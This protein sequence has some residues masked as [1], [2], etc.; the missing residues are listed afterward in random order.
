MSKSLF[1]QNMQNV[2]KTILGISEYH[3]FVNTV[4]NLM[5]HKCEWQHTHWRICVS[6]TPHMYTLYCLSIPNTFC[7]L[8]H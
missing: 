7:V 3:I 2:P 6:K 1:G 5:T 8:W 4:C